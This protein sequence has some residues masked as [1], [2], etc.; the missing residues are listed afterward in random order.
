MDSKI[1][2]IV[3]D[4]DLTALTTAEKSYGDS[5]KKRGGVGAFMMLARKWDRLE[6]AIAPPNNKPWNIFAMIKSDKRS[7]GIIDDIRDLRRYLILVESEALEQGWCPA[8]LAKDAPPE[9][10][11]IYPEED[12]QRRAV[13]QALLV[14]DDSDIDPPAR[15]LHTAPEKPCPPRPATSERTRFD[16]L[17]ELMSGAHHDAARCGKSIPHAWDEVAELALQMVELAREQKR[18]LL[19]SKSSVSSAKDD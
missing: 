8:P 6:N 13:H 11:S 14:N 3:V 17:M 2:Q 7:E 16:A 12:A 19:E 4:Q 18:K 9:L 15:V 5:W 10:R 1:R